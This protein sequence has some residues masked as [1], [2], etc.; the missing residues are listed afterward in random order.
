MVVVR[1][2]DYKRNIFGN[3]DPLEPDSAFSGSFR[4]RTGAHNDCFLASATD[5]GTYGN[6]EEDKTYLNL[7][8]R[9]VPQGGETCNPSEYSGCENALIDLNRMHW[10]VLNRDYHPGV[11]EGWQNNGCWDEIQRR[12]GYR[13]ELQEARI[14]DEVRPG[15]ELNLDLT[16]FNDGFASPYNPRNCEIVIRNTATE[17]EYT[18]VSAADPRWWLG[19]DTAEVSISGGIPNNLPEG[20]YAV[21]LHLADPA[22]LM[23]YRPEFSIQLANEGIWEA[24][25]GYNNLIHTL[26]VS[27]SATGADYTDDLWFEFIEATSVYEHPAVLKPGSFELRPGYP[28]P[29]NGN[30]SISLDVYESTAIGFEVFNHLGQRVDVISVQQY[31]PGRH[32][33]NWRPNATLSSGHYYFRAG[34]DGEF[35]VQ[36]LVYLK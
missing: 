22:P 18:L 17:I 20:Q 27:A 7:D 10:S 15:G 8:N 9:F 32:A 26:T 4:A 29:F 34:A 16:I 3:D 13:F 11:I 35:T 31:E 19:G 21:Y 12:L 28:N 25:T 30:Y 6:I 23:R 5:Y 1:T 33:L 14:Q 36:K 2:P 24:E